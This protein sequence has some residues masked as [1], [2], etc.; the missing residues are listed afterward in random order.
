MMLKCHC[1][2]CQ[3]MTGSGFSPAVL[4]PAEEFRV[5]R[6]ELRYYFTESSAGGR[7]RRGFCAQCGSL[8]TGGENSERPTGVVGV[9]AGTLDDPGLF[10]P[11][12]DIFVSDAQPWDFM[13][14]EL[15][16]FAEYPPF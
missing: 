8:V 13:N 6:G 3:Q 4:V 9:T 15:P 16:K 11:Q 10:Q 7:H 1:R 14:P 5:T 2:N 12:M